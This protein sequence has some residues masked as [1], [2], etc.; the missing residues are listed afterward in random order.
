MAYK[1]LV[2]PDASK[3]IEEAVSYYIEHASKKVASKFLQDYKKAVAD[4]LKVRYFQVCY[5]NFRGRMMRTFPYIVFYTID[6]E[7][8]IIVVKAVFHTAQNPIKHPTK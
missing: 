1:I 7:Q 4:I 6:E 3:Q 2:T 5:L 8:Q